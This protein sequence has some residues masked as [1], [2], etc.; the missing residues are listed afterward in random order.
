[1]KT[2]E[3]VWVKSLPDTLKIQVIYGFLKTPGLGEFIDSLLMCKDSVVVADMVQIGHWFYIH[4]LWRLY[5]SKLDCGGGE[6]RGKEGGG[7]RRE[8]FVHSC[9]EYA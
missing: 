8:L 6:G 7:G 3:D 1:M 4:P 9:W 5:N 2:L